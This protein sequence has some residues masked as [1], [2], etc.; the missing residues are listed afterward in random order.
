MNTVGCIFCEK[1]GNVGNINQHL[2]NYFD[3]SRTGRVSR[4][5]DHHNLELIQ[6]LYHLTATAQP[7]LVR[8]TS[9][10]RFAVL[11]AFATRLTHR[12]ASDAAV[13]AWRHRDYFARRAAWWGRE[14]D[15]VLALYTAS[16]RIPDLLAAHVGTIVERAGADSLLH[17]DPPSPVARRGLGRSQ[18]VALAGPA[19]TQAPRSELNMQYTGSQ[20]GTGLVMDSAMRNWTS[21]G[22]PA[23][24]VRKRA[25][26][27]VRS[28]RYV[29]ISDDDD[30]EEAP[31]AK[32]TASSGTPAANAHVAAFRSFSDSAMNAKKDDG[33]APF[34]A[35]QVRGLTNKLATLPVAYGASLAGALRMAVERAPSV[36]RE[37]GARVAF[38]GDAGSEWEGEWPEWRWD[39]VMSEAEKRRVKIVLRLVLVE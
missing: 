16:G 21:R 8:T 2:R 12:L 1:T 22:E 14:V 32:R 34:L 19:K 38:V 23:I 10:D 11:T 4:G 25:G 31:A 3:A 37:S 20:H 7:S 36:V 29:T 15:T 28:T 17:D 30:D 27:A 33:M 13:H 5:A 26:G 6:T 35:L 9:T 18:T 24:A 39:E